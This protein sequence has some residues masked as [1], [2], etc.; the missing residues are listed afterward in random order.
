[1]QRRLLL[2]P[3]DAQPL[4]KA[5]FGRWYYSEERLRNVIKDIP[6]KSHPGRISATRSAIFYA[7][8]CLRWLSSYAE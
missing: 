4:I 8:S 3:V 5:L 2:D 6:K 1:M 7:G